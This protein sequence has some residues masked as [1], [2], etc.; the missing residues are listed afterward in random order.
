MNAAFEAMMEQSMAK[1]TTLSSTEARHFL[2]H[3]WVLVKGA[4]SKQIAADIVACAWRELE[5]RGIMKDDPE[6]WKQEPYIR[7]GCP[8][9]LNI[10]ASRGD[11]EA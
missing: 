4:V 11:K 6:T 1:C 5:E 10:M 2:E 8:P 7:T 9:N 3:G